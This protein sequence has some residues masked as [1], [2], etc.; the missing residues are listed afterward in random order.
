MRAPMIRYV[1]VP[2]LLAV[3]AAPAALRA[4]SG[5]GT[6]AQQVLQLPAG[7]RAA[8]FGGAYAGAADADV[9]FYNPAG[10]G[11]LATA[12]AFSY[13]RHVQD[14]SFGTL[15]LARAVGPVVVGV[16]VA[17]LNA[18]TIDVIEPDPAYGGERGRPTGASAS[19]TESAT[20][21]TI[22]LPVG[23]RVRLGAAAG[24]ATSAIAGATRSAPFGDL[25]AQ[26]VLPRVT[27]GASVRNLGGRLT[28]DGIGAD[29]PREARLG[30]E[31][32]LP[33]GAG[34]GGRVSADWVQ[35]LV[36]GTGWI[37]GGVEAGLPASASRAVGL[38]GRVG[39]NAGG[40]ALQGALTLG[41]GL[42]VRGL[43]VDYAWQRMDAFGS[44]HRLG[45]RWAR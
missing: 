16:G 36:G 45:V 7:A 3:P 40:D 18:G 13:Q 17:Y 5:A 27:V 23:E 6:A 32:E 30:A 43:A 12:A 21:L 34:L 31:A 10:S 14:V 20:R 9:L 26:L 38:L 8:A 4:Q 11:G 2:C 22:A 41:G 44:V 24:F 33:G 28:G 1:V 29:L 25:G 39:Y 15:A 37:A 42:Q 19:A 35:D